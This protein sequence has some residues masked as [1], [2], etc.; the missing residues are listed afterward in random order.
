MRSGGQEVAGVWTWVVWALALRGG[1]QWR[2]RAEDWHGQTSHVVL[3]VKNPPAN[4]GDVRDAGSVPGLA[5]SSRGGHGHPLRCW[6]LR[7]LVGPQESDQ[8]LS[9]TRGGGQAQSLTTVLPN[10]GLRPCHNSLWHHLFSQDS[11]GNRSPAPCPHPRPPAQ[12]LPVPVCDGEHQVSELLSDCPNLCPW[13]RCLDF[14]INM[15]GYK[16]WLHYLSAMTLAK[17]PNCLSL[18]FL[19]IKWA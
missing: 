19:S 10:S 4:A 6:R 1:Q 11:G 17:L 5:R 14:G 16:S 18:S 13:K 8:G 7:S 3:V 2:I 12:A 9:W 15:S